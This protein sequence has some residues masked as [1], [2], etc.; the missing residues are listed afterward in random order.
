MEV[1]EKWRI[2]HKMSEP[3]SPPL[4][5]AWYGELSE[6]HPTE[7]QTSIS[8]SSAVKLNMTSASC[9][10]YSFIFQFIYLAFFRTTSYFGIPDAPSHTNLVQMILTLK[11]V[12]LAFEVHDTAAASA[13]K[14]DGGS[15]MESTSKDEAIS[16]NPGFLDIFHYSFAYIGVLTGPYY[17]YRTYHDWL[18]APFSDYAPCYEETLRKFKLVPLYAAV[19]LLVSYIY[20]IQYAMSDEFYNERSTLYRFWYIWPTFLIFRMRIYIGMTLSECVCITAGLGAYP[21]F[22]DPKSGQGPT[23]EYHHLKE[24]STNPEKASKE[25]YS[26]ETVHNLDASKTEFA[27]TMRESIRSWNMTIQYWMAV[28]VYKRL[29]RSPF[30]TAIT[31]FVS[32]FWHGMYAGHYLCICSTALYIPVEDLYARHLRK[33]VSSTFGKIFDFMLCYIRMLSFSYM[34]ITFILLRIDAAFKYW[35]SI[36]FACHILWAVLYVVGFVLI[37]RGKKKVDTDTKSK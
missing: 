4:P 37:K 11:L 3:P 2:V 33:K 29:P 32:A 27:T 30:R 5:P 9:H 12:G 1:S 8:P 14:V 18:H 19:F 28:N 23:K 17:S 26:F 7:I 15:D 22:T 35:A 20:P 10:L 25:L 21:V 34:G 36:Y 24:I 6:V 13:R 31:T 16:I